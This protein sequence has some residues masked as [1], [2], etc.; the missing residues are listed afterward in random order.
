[1]SRATTTSPNKTVIGHVTLREIKPGK[2]RIR[3]QDPATGKDVQLRLKA[4]TYP[5]AVADAE[6]HNRYCRGEVEAP[7]HEV[8]REKAKAMGLTVEEAMKQAEAGLNYN[9][10]TLRDHRLNASRFRE[11]AEE[12]GATRW[13]QIS[14][15]LIR[16]FYRQMK[17]CQLAHDTIR[18]RL[19]PVSITSAYWALESDE[20]TDEFK[21]AQI[22]HKRP[23][24]WEPEIKH[25]TLEETRAFLQHL[26]ENCP[27]KYHALAMLG[28]YTG[29]RQL[30]IASLR[31]CDVDAQTRIITV[32]D[33]ETHDVKTEAS[34]RR[35]PVPQEVI[36]SIRV[37]PIDPQGLLFRSNG[38]CAYDANMLSK[39]WRKHVLQKARA[40]EIVPAWFTAKKMRPTFATLAGECGLDEVMLQRAMGHAPASTMARF[41]RSISTEAI[42]ESLVTFWNILTSGPASEV[43]STAHAG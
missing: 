19:L 12:E 11:F 33:T 20:Y 15:E 38:G 39:E 27:W 31:A 37:W 36:D 42:R 34:K 25:L 5:E 21:R 4:G 32:T 6:A 24:D 35:V 9:T 29:M 22:K 30:E 1:M 40:E 16:K 28:F 17:A 8:K 10:Q 18:L 7:P 3:Y 13:K 14:R 41:Y 2:W 26:R 23:K 43:E